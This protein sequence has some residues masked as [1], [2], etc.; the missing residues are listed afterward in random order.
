MGV[1]VNTV[2]NTTNIQSNLRHTPIHDNLINSI[3]KLQRSIQVSFS[4]ATQTCPI[5]NECF[6]IQSGIA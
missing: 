4:K 6:Q 2:K 5:V 1:V 3:S